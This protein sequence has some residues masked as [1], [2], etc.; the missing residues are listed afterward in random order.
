MLDSLLLFSKMKIRTAADFQRVFKQR[1]K[2]HSTH[3]TFYYYKNELDYLRFGVITSKRNVRLSVNRNRIR[4]IVKETMR[5]NQY[6]L[7]GLDV[8]IVANPQ[9]EQ[10][11][12]QELQQ[13]LAMLIARLI[14]H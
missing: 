4:R 5:T 3:F 14:K 12:N 1:K 8:V 2:I 6:L 10:A 11:H 13:C 7:P 9:G